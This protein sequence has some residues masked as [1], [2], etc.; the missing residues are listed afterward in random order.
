MNNN[1]NHHVPETTASYLFQ[2]DPTQIKTFIGLVENQ[3]NDNVHVDKAYKTAQNY[4]SK[5]A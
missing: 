1:I 3:T 4:N 2:Q 5:K